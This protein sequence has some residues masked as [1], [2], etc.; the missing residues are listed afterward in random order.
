MAW[1]KGF[2]ETL[3]SLPGLGFKVVQ[4]LGFRLVQG[5]GF[6]LVQG[7]GFRLVQG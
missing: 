1:F 2:V 5:L 6:R 4:C 3:L 7:S